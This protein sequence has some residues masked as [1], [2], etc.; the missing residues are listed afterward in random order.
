MQVASQTASHSP[1]NGISGMHERK[2][3]TDT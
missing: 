3:H 1:S 2:R